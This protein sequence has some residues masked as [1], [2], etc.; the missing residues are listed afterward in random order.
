[1]NCGLA[2]TTG[3]VTRWTAALPADRY[4]LR[5]VPAEGAPSLMRR[6]SAAQLLR[7]VPWMRAMNR[8]GHH[9]YARPIATRHVLVDDL[10][11]DG[12]NAI[13]ARHRLAAVVQTSPH[14]HQAWITLSASPVEPALAAAVARRLAAEFGGDPGAASAVQVGRLPGFTNPKQIYERA[15]GLFPFA[16]LIRLEPS[17]DPGG[18]A[19]LLAAAA[20]CSTKAVSHPPRPTLLAPGR[21]RPCS[22]AEEWA[23]AARRVREVLPPRYTLDRSRLDHALARR[24][25]AR[26]AGR[27]R[28]EAVLLAGERAREMLPAAALAYARRTIEAAFITAVQDAEKG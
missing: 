25:L 8:V 10:C 20:S 22:A 19:L 4:D 16:K 21:L 14:N 2:L 23:E 15:D 18:D 1:M 24:L 3:A 27:E 13:G 17:V 5:L 12:L 6:L 11:P 28:V 26:G 7:A 9:V